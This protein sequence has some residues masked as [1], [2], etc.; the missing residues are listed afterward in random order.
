VLRSLRDSCHQR[1]PAQTHHDINDVPDFQ[2]RV[3]EHESKS[4][5]RDAIQGPVAGLSNY[6]GN[7]KIGLDMSRFVPSKSK[8]GMPKP[9]VA[10]LKPISVP[11]NAEN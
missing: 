8:N 2:K 1:C 6:A 10:S 9:R 5:L 3:Y 4:E 7:E 11:S